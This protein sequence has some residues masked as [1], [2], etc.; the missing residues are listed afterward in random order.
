M[1]LATLRT[2]EPA[3]APSNVVVASAKPFGGKGS[4]GKEPRSPTEH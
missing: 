3:P 4:D 2:G 1:L